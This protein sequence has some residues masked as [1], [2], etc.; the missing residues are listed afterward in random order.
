M[1]WTWQAHESRIA[2]AWILFWLALVSASVGCS[3]GRIEALREKE[4][5]LGLLERLGGR[6]E[7]DGNS[8]G[9]PF[10]K[11]DLNHSAVADADLEILSTLTDLQSLNLDGSAHL[12]DA[13]M[14]HLKG[15][16][17]LR[18]LS[19]AFTPITDA[20]LKPLH[21]LAN[22][23]TLN[24]WSCRVTDQGVKELQEKL[25]KVQVVR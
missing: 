17:N 8:P 1:K 13:G 18:F 9:Q 20:G 7:I 2:R 6:Y 25:P 24:L 23:Q 11:I 10:V 21:D 3:K 19:L 16:K 15:L 5:V 12:S 4:R 14:E 22:L